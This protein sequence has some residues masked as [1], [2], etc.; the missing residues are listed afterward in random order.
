M[1]VVSRRSIIAGVTASLCAPGLACATPG[2]SSDVIRIGQTMPYSGPASAYGVV[3]RAELAVFAM[4]NAQG[5]VNGR[6]V[7]LLSVDDGYSP[8]RTVEETRRLVESEQVAFMY[9]GL[10]TAPQAAV[11]RYLKDIEK[12]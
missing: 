6:R 9:Q 12:L 7:D 8:P 4:I 3:G 1:T 10:G 2:I 5:G 11:Q